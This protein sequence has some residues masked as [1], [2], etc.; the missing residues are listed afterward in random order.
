MPKGE[1]RATLMRARSRRSV[2]QSV[3]RITVR[4]ARSKEFLPK[5]QVKVIG[6]NN[7]T[8]FSG[9]TDL[10]MSPYTTGIPAAK[11]GK[12]RGF[13]LDVTDEEGCAKL[14]RDLS[15]LVGPIRILVKGASNVGWLGE[16]ELAE[17][18]AQEAFAT[19][20]ERW[21]RDGVPANPTGWLITTA[22]NRAIDRIRRE[23]TLAAKTDP[24]SRRARAISRNRRASSR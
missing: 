17:D 12:A 2:R 20:A 22:R 14:A 24:A 16:I 6:S 11:G 8:F 21:P 3:I 7:P 15:L 19:A 9:E 10:T 1:K 18:A 4:D 5:V 13:M 23:R